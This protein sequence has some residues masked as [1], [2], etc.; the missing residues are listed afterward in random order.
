M[1]KTYTITKRTQAITHKDSNYF[2][3]IIEEDRET[4]SSLTAHHIIDFNCK[5][6]GPSL[7]SRLEIVKDIL[8]SNSKLPVPIS[9]VDGI[10]MFPT[11]SMRGDYVAWLAY[12]HIKDYKQRNDHTYI[13][14]LDDTGL[15]VKASEHVIDKQYKRT[16]QVIIHYSRGKLFGEKYDVRN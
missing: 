6:T 9:P 16:G 14:F 5:K 7:K 15:Y 1:K 10:Y 11:G 4:Y 3:T 2:R 12:H 13:K 8:Q